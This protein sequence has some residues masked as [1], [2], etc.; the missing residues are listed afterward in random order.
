MSLSYRQP[1]NRW[2]LRPAEIHVCAVALAA[3]P[4][5]IAKLE[6]V[7]SPEERQRARRFRTAELTQ[8]F[9]A[10]RGILRTILGGCL[11]L[12]PSDVP[13]EYGERG[14]P[15]IRGGGRLRFNLSHSGGQALYALAV[16]CEVGVD[17]ERIRPMPDC[18][19]IAERFFSAAEQRD[20]RSAPPRQREA[21]FFTCWTRKEAY[22]KAVGDGLSLPLDSFRVSLL[23]SEPPTLDARGDSQEWSL[24]DVS[25]GQSYAAALVAEGSRTEVRGWAFGDAGDCTAYFG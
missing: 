9:V 13:L 3:S 8:A 20:L 24:F 18:E 5:C 12:P 4:V 25:P 15:R 14:K 17:L 11:H 2:E 23:P 6:G 19:S 10:G 21:A 16:D 1:P 7:L 22:I